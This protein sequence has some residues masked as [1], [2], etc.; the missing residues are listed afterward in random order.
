MAGATLN[1]ALPYPSST[2]DVNLFPGVNQTALETVDAEL[3][4]R[5]PKASPAF[6]GTPTVPT[7]ANGTRTTQAAST[8]FA[9]GLAD[10]LTAN[11]NNLT[12]LT[13]MGA[14]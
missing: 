13:L 4:L 5:A 14:L 3:A 2:D 10:T 12:V 9:G 1:Y 11:L 6:T 7:A 8:A